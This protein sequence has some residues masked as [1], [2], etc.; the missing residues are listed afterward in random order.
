MLR[1]SGDVAD[2]VS[3]LSDNFQEAL[4]RQL[5]QSVPGP[6]FAAVLYDTGNL[7]GRVEDVQR[8]LVIAA[9]HRSTDSLMMWSSRSL[10][11]PAD[12]TST[13]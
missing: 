12:T 9:A 3:R 5:P 4:D 11:P 6:R 8:P 7:F 1:E 10:S 2:G 13:G